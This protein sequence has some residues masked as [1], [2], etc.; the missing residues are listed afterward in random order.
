VQETVKKLLGKDPD[1]VSTL[2]NALL[3]GSHPGAV[4]TGE[5]KDIV[6]LDVTLSRLVSKLSAGLQPSS[7]SATP[8]SRPEEQIFSTAADGQT[9][10]EI[11]LSRVNGHWRRTISRW[12]VP[13]DRHSPAP[14]AY[15]RLK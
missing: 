8:Q 1:K 11:M 10:V 13:V 7:S 4:L 14:V 5:T 15:L 12:Q 6:L 3:S 2:M 9:S